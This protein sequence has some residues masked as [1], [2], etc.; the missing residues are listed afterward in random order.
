MKNRFKSYLIPIIVITLFSFM[1]VGFALY[2]Q[3][4]SLNGD[5]TIAEPGKIAITSATY[6]TS[7]NVN[8]PTDPSVTEDGMGINFT[9]NCSDATCSVTYLIKVENK[10][11]YDYTFTNLPINATITSENNKT[12]T[13]TATIYDVDDKKELEAGTN[14]AVGDTVNI[15]LKLDFELGK[16]GTIGGTGNV[17]ASEDNSGSIVPISLSPTEGNLQ[18]GNEMPCFTA[19]ISN[20]FKYAR[21][22]NFSSENDL[23]LLV[24]NAGLSLGEQT[25][26]ANSTDEFEICTV[27]SEDAVFASDTTTTNI[28]L[29]STGVSDVTVGHLTFKVDIAEEKI[30]IPPSVGDV[31]VSISE[32][33]ENTG[34]VYVSW[35]RTD[36]TGAEIA[37]YY[38]YL[39]KEG[40]STPITGT[41]HGT[42]L[43]LNSTYGNGT[44]YAIVYAEDA[45]NNNGL[46]ETMIDGNYA[47]QAEALASATTDSGYISK[48]ESTALNWTFTVTTSLTGL[49]SDGAETA[50]LY[51]DYSATITLTAAAG[52][53]FLGT[54]PTMPSDL[55]IKLKVLIMARR[56]H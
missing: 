12:P 10:S 23:I 28:I 17:S 14:I 56:L 25:I 2:G 49:A 9:L 19:V 13:V 1:S 55:T 7:T 32:T 8:N 42:S 11:F 15:R 20:T 27:V 53:G 40:E 21:S 16:A 51:R 45:F 3:T 29:S 18:I 6:V 31:A 52:S 44:Y 38:V 22:I 35:S 36:S 39:Y 46:T 37:A 48:S 33:Y 30:E 43:T 26:G 50:Y 41:T 24:D 47:T 5:I 34:D 54:D 4:V